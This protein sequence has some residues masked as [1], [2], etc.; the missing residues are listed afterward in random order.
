[1]NQQQEPLSAPVAAYRETGGIQ[2]GGAWWLSMNFSWPF[3]SLVADEDGLVVAVSLGKLWGRRFVLERSKIVSIHRKRGFTAT[4][5]LIRH[6]DEAIPPHLVFW[7]VRYE[8]LRSALEER[9]YR[10][11][12]DLGWHGA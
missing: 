4:G 12:D 6:T 2:Y 10:V 8:G 5:V 11:H 1:M 9:G 3:A 7:S